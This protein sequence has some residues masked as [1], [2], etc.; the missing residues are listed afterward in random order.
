[1]IYI[2]GFD[3][4]VY[5]CNPCNRAKAFCEENKLE[6]Q[7]ISVADVVLD[8]KPIITDTAKRILEFRL[9]VSSIDG[10]TMPQ[11]F[12]DDEHLGGSSDFIEYKT[13]S[14]Y[15]VPEGW[16][17]KYP[18]IAKMADQQMHTFWP[19]DEPAVDNDIQDLMLN[20]TDGEKHGVMETLKLF[21]LYEMRVG[22]DYWTG[23]IE[24][25]FRRPE[26][27]RMSTM[28]GATEFNS[29]APFYNKFNEV[30]YLDNEEF[31]SAWKHQDHLSVRM[32]FIGKAVSDK[33]DARSIAAFSFIEGAVLYSSFAFLKH[34]QA[35]MYGKNLIKNIV[36]GVDLSVADEHLHSVGGA[37][38]FNILCKE[39]PSTRKRLEQDVVKMAETVI[40]HEFAII[41]IIFAK[42]IRG[43]DINHM[44]S[45][46]KHRVN[47][48]LEQLGYDY[49]FDVEDATIEEWFYTN[50]NAIKF[51]DFFSGA[52]SEYSI[53]WKKEG[54]KSVWA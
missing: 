10:M 44:K 24:K 13:N 19:W 27:Q 25:T 43:L 45:F 39:K 4:S 28:F 26:F 51:H 33:D 37:A 11:I 23:R 1:M 3:P 34:F 14:V 30:L 49:R 9:G 29:H 31:Y 17:I 8:G 16:I 5:N 42:G 52:G 54:F 12:E 7:F 20:M 47:V 35:Q 53:N 46:V 18:E 15:H 38:I 6:Y 48:C 21:T 2:F 32:E 40:D 50:I 22:S 41:D 36:R